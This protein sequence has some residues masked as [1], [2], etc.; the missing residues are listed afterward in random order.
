MSWGCKKI[1]RVVTSSLAAETVPLSSVLHQLSWIRLCWAWMLDPKV[2]WQNPDKAPKDLPQSSATVKT[3][4]L[5]EGLAATDCKL[6]LDL[7][8]RTGTPRCSEF[9]TLLNAKT[10]MK[11]MLEE[12]IQLRCVQLSSIS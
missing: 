8:A 6:L 12:G 9:R 10:K 7:V 4:S 3:Q 1:Q 5:P 2:Q 11:E